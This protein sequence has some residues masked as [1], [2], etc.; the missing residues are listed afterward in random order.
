MLGDLAQREWMAVVLGSTL[1]LL[2]AIWILLQG[3]SLE[4]GFLI[5]F[6]Q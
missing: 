3:Q 2:L 1:W 5:H 4:M 6:H